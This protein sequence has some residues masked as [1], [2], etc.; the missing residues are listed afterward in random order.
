MTERLRPRLVRRTLLAAVLTV[1][2]LAASACQPHVGAAGYVGNQRI[3]E[4]QVDSLVKDARSQSQQQVT[5]ADLKT[6]RDRV[7]QLMVV[8]AALDASTERLHLSGPSDTEIATAIDQAAASGQQL[9]KKSPLIRLSARESLEAQAIGDELT[10]NVQVPEAALL[11]AYQSSPLAQS[12]QP[13][14]Q[15]RDQVRRALLQ[16]QAQS[17]A[18]NYIQKELQ[19]LGVTL[20]PRYGTFN[21]KTGEVTAVSNNFVKVV[22]EQPSSQP[23]SATQQGGSSGDGPPVG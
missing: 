2:L 23:S 13:F 3:T 19:R 6:L 11:Q 15:V 14:A 4:S 21:L 16:Q 22:S 8:T 1:G 17:A 7:V 18:G 12:G 5:D 9:D 20:N 10:K